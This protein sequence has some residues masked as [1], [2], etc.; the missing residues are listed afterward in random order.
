ME[1]INNFKFKFAKWF[2]TMVNP[3]VHPF[4]LANE[5]NIPYS[6]WQYEKGK[7]TIKLYLDYTTID[8][9]FKDKVVLDI[10]CGA[11]GKSLF[12]A[13]SGAK[14]VVGI[15]IVEHYR[16]EAEALA[17]D[18][19]LEDK[20]EFV[21]GDASKMPFE[22]NSFDTII[23]NDAMEHVDDPVSVLHEIE[24]VLKPGGRLY[25]NFPPYYHPYGAHLSDVMGT[26]WIQMFFSEET[27]A[28]VYRDLVKDLPDGDMRVQFRIGQDEKGK[29]YFKYI[30]HM[31]LKRFKKIKRETNLKIIYEKEV[32]LRWFFVPFA[33]LP[34]FK[35]AFVKM[36][37]VV[38]EKK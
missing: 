7:D 1:K 25:V 14:K 10:G 2:T 38:F 26:P 23:M 11:A 30:N 24:R 36:K 32:P 5:K 8:E 20:F 15:E 22:E 35:E 19:G 13:K 37:V 33:K 16:E 12:Y 3:P 18:L 27:L 9:M 17:K 34:L 21:V 28:A 31:T 4:N 29:D 6:R